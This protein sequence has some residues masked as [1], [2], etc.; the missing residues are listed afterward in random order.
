[1]SQLWPVVPNNRRLKKEREF[2]GRLQSS[3]TCFAIFFFLKPKEP[4][5]TATDDN[6]ITT[7]KLKFSGIGSLE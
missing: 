2:E 3:V 5:S 4:T 6:S 1:L 7:P